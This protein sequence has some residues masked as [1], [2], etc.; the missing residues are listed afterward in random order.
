MDYESLLELVM[1]RRSTHAYKPDPVSD[2]DVDKILEAARW[3][4]SG[5]NSQPWE[6]VVV[7][8]AAVRAQIVEL[9][10]EQGE[11]AYKV[12]QTRSPEYRHPSY[13]EPRPARYGFAAAPVYIVTCGDPRT[14]EAYPLPAKLDRGES[15]YYS[16]LASAFLYMHLAATA[17]GLGCQWVSASGM[18]LMQGRLKGLLDIP[19]ELDIYDMM[20]LGY[21][22]SG[23]RSRK[24]RPR[25][26]IVHREKFDRG[27]Y[28]T[29]QEVRAFID[30]LWKR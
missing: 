5:A 13:R 15:N 14:K 16:S 29:D 3:A 20:A 6:F 2:E 22:A 11:I 26:E 17:L 23:P 7:K 28:R 9:F 21:P 8:D 10:K 4:P 30:S 25:E 18:D 19:Y 24:V 27:R 12:E 1:K